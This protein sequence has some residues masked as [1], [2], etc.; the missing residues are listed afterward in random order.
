RAPTPQLSKAAKNTP[1]LN[2]ARE[3][4][5]VSR[6]TTVEPDKIGCGVIPAAEPDVESGMKSV[7]G[8]SRTLTRTGRGL[9][10]HPAPKVVGTRRRRPEYLPQELRQ[11]VLRAWR[12]GLS[13]S[14]K[15]QHVE[16]RPPTTRPGKAHNT[17]R[18]PLV[19]A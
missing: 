10:V 9:V 6:P 19:L 2:D 17:C 18:G 16:R 11:E 3:E 1:G 4:G 13:Y 15:S 8:A 5:R 14:R 12:V 7:K